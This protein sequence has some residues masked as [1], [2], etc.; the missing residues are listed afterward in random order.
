MKKN[1][2]YFLPVF[3][4]V[5]LAVTANGESQRRK[6][7]S[8]GDNVNI[9][10]MPLI[11]SEVVNQL[12]RDEEVFVKGVDG[13]WTEIVPPFKVDLWIH[14][15]FVQNSVISS[16]KVNVRAGP[17]I[18]FSIV[19]QLVNGDKVVTRGHSAEW[20]NI[21]PP[22][23]CSLWVAS[24]YLQPIPV[25]EPEPV[26][27]EPV[28][29]EPV[30]PEPVKPEPV[31][32]SVES[33][34]TAPEDSS[35]KDLIDEK[36]DES[37]VD[38]GKKDESVDLVPDSAPAPDI[39]TEPVHQIEDE[40]AATVSIS[41]NASKAP[42]VDES[43]QR[44]EFVKPPADLDLVPAQQQGIVKSYSGILRPAGY[45]FN[46]PS[47]FRILSHD[48][49]GKSVMQCYVKGN[50]SQL[51]ALLGRKMTIT[52]RQYWVQGNR[53]PVLVPNRIVVEY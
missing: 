2:F 19:G 52:G 38:S 11:T 43:A 30:K 10:A 12:D 39:K 41:D 42:S 6:F 1:I 4:S 22:E 47:P 7:K 16:P 3:I 13:E 45:L 27:S 20:M 44:E 17:G 48:E 49:S 31:E 26:K 18:N 36:I 5:V 25:A 37:P 8:T 51:R 53:Y 50:T 35:D 14:Q 24:S 15:D 33:A 34:Q 23:K 40:I 28:K 21:E 46:R 9:R 32:K 29:P